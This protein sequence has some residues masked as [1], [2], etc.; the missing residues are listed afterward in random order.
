MKR[1]P[2]ARRRAPPGRPG[3]SAC[4]SGR[5]DLVV[6][7]RCVDV[8]DL[9]ATATVRPG[10]H[11]GGRARGARLRPGRGRPPAQPRRPARSPSSPTS[12]SRHGASRPDRRPRR[13]RPTTT[14]TALPGGDHRRPPAG[15]PSP[16]PAPPTG[17]ARRRRR[18]GARRL[19]PG[20]RTRP[21]D[22]RHRP[23]RRARPPGR[24]T[25]LVDADPYGGTVA[26]ALGVLDEVSGLLAAARLA[27]SGMLEERFA[28]VQRALD[29]QLTVVTGLPRPDRW[30]EVRPGTVELLAETARRHGHVV[31]DT[32]FSLERRTTS[33]AGP[34]AT[35]SPWPRSTSPTRC[36]WS[37]PPTR[38]ACRGW[39][40]PWSTCASG[41]RPT[42]VRVVVN[43]MRPDA[44]LVRA[45]RRPDARRLRAPGRAALPARGPR[46]AST[47]PWSPAAPCSRPTPRA[48]SPSRSAG[49]ADAIVP[50]AGAG[51]RARAR[52]GSGGE[53]QVQPTRGEADHRDQQRQ[54]AGEL[55]LLRQQVDGPVVRGDHADHVADH[56]GQHLDAWPA[57]SG[58][59]RRS[60]TPASSAV[61]NQ[62]APVAERVAHVDDRLLADL[63]QVGQVVGDDVADRRSA[64]SSARTGRAARGAAGRAR[65]R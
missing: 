9:L 62:L 29:Q 21:H 40:A 58:G 45:R 32:G 18:A 24:R 5:R 57:R 56:D 48:R 4:S 11:R 13:R 38:S 63:E 35:S 2:A 17:A 27:G 33:A 22:G 19:G 26:Q 59:R 50:R 43:R 37:A 14:S 42:P 64:R 44:R 55:V 6:L 31:I 20:R 54:L 46:H 1:R 34:A 15:R 49:L 47:A 53:Q 12:S 30:T 51:A 61:P 28:S 8:D 65:R 52:A 3:R 23:G 39:P 16:P 25:T 10:R 41:S 36:W 60:R 7:K